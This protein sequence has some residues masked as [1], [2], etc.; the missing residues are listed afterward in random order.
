MSPSG[1]EDS[2]LFFFFG[3]MKMMSP[4]KDW[5]GLLAANYKY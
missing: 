3:I 5:A 4:V 2:F 1:G